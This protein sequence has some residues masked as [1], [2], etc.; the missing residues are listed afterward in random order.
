[1]FYLFAT[2]FMVL[3]VLSIIRFQYKGESLAGVRAGNFVPLV[4]LRLPAVRSGKH[5]YA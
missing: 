3:V 4:V 2:I 5:E 1:M